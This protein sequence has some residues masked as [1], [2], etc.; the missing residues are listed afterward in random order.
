VAWAR[1]AE[2]LG[3]GEI[4]LTAMDADGGQ[5]GYDL[6]ITRLVADAVGIPVV[7]SGGAGSL[8]H[9]LDAVTV[10]GADAALAASIFHF[11][12]HTIP[13]AKRYLAAHGVPVR[14]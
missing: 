4:V 13:E 6:H 7:A 12:T 14:P 5:Q 3:A 11:G 8:R 1:Q 2:A 10:G 9:L